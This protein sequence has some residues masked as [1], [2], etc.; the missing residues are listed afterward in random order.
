MV[1]A[2]KGRLSC[3]VKIS[4]FFIICLSF[5]VACKA[6]F[7]FSNRSVLLSVMQDKVSLDKSLN[8]MFIVVSFFFIRIYI[9]SY[10]MVKE[11]ACQKLFDDC[12]KFGKMKVL[13][14]IVRVKSPWGE[15]LLGLY[16]LC[17]G[18]DFYNNRL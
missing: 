9:I 8:R 18:L 3:S 17:L 7:P 2:F 5:S 6:R 1:R 12:N 4:R 14:S 13:K 15:V 11:C 10:E 16:C